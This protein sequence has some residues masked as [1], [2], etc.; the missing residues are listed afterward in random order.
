MWICVFAT[1]DLKEAFKRIESLKRKLQIVCEQKTCLSENLI[2]RSDI[3]SDNIFE[4][5]F[6][7][8]IR[9]KR[10]EKKTTRINGHFNAILRKKK[11][12]ECTSPRRRHELC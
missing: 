10:E 11:H 4:S 3:F 9:K 1:V 12:T 8:E 5:S 6:A 7:K 2:E